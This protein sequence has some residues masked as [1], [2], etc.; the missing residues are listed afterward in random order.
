MQTVWHW[1]LLEVSSW[2]NCSFVQLLSRSDHAVFAVLSTQFAVLSCAL[3]LSWKPA[4]KLVACKVEGG[5]TLRASFPSLRQRMAK[6]ET[7]AGTAG[8]ASKEG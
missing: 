6:G 8:Q 7:S 4:S 3:P 2:L 1:L 5:P